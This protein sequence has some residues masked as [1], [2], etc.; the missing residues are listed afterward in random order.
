MWR[1]SQGVFEMMESD[2]H[3]GLLKSG[4]AKNVVNERRVTVKK[5]IIKIKEGILTS[6][7]PEGA[8]NTSAAV[9]LEGGSPIKHQLQTFR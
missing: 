2:S 1:I 4:S 9:P 8:P 7:T 5:K 3:S 6:D